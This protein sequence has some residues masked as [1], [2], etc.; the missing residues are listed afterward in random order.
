MPRLDRAYGL[1]PARR[2]YLPD[3]QTAIVALWRPSV[4]SLSRCREILGSSCP[5][6]DSE[7]EALR[8]QL[9]AIADI[10][11]AIGREGV[12]SGAASTFHER[13]KLVS[14]EQREEIVERAAI[15]EIDGGL[16]RAEAEEAALEI[17]IRARLDGKCESVN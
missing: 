4:L 8:D 17:W 7:L 12:K 3:A 5:E 13:L 16:R 10:A 9:M 6:T 14:D 15:M 11:L 1:C 2:F